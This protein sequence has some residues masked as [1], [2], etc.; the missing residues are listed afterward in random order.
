[1][2]NFVAILAIFF[3]I[4]GTIS[5]AIGLHKTDGDCLKFSVVIFIITIC[6]TYLAYN[7]V[8]I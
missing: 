8:N 6:F 4:I 1:M 5:L 7:E 2:N 3:A